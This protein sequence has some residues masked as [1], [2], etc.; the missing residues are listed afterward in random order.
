MRYLER[1]SKRFFDLLLAGFM[2]TKDL[3]LD[4]LFSPFKLLAS[5][6]IR[7]KIAATITLILALTVFSL[8]FVTFTRQTLIL[9]EELQNRA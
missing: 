5:I 2:E 6:S 9:R 7:F 3:L 4:W 1:K 8:G